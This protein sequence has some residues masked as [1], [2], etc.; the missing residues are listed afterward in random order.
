MNAAVAAVR[1]QLSELQ[2]NIDPSRD[3]M[4]RLNLREAE[5]LLG[6]CGAA[7]AKLLGSWVCVGAVCWVLSADAVLLR[8]LSWCV[9]VG[10]ETQ[11]CRVAV[12]WL[13][14]VWWWNFAAAQWQRQQL[15]P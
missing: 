6:R 3:N 10:E 13:M 11:A 5:D 2:G 15:P 1:M 4:I 9:C 12:P 14:L 7:A 8:L